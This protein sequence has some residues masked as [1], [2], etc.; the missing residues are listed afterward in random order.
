MEKCPSRKGRNEFN[1]GLNTRTAIYIPFAQAIPNVACIDPE[2]C[3]KLKTGK[4]GLCEKVCSAGAINYQQ[5]DEIIER[6]Y[7][8]IVAAT[9]FKPIDLDGF[10]EYGYNTCK[11]VVTSLEFER[12]MNAAGPTKGQLVRPSDG[13]HPHEIVFIQCV[14][15]RCS[16]DAGK[17]KPYCSKICCMYTAK[18][19]MLVRDK[20]PDVNVHVFYIDVRTP[21]KN[22]D[23]F[24]RRA[25][26]QY[27]VEYIKGMVGKVWEQDGKLM[28]QGSDLINNEQR[29]IA[30]DMVVLA[31]GVTPDTAL[32]KDAGL[33]LGIKGSIV[34][35]DRMET[36]VEDIYA[37]GDAVQVSHLV[38]GDDALI[39][40]AGPANKQGRVAAD[41]ICGL[42]S[43][44]AGAQGTS[45]IKVFD[46]TAAATGLSE[47]ACERAGIAHDAVVLSP[48]SHAGY[49]PGGKVMTM[50]VVFE[51]GT[52]RLLGAQIVGYEGVD[53]RIDVLATAIHAGLSALQLKDLDLAYAPPYS[54]AKDPVNMAGFMIENLSHGLV[55][56]FFPEDVDALP[57]DGS[58]T[59]LD[60]RTPGEYAAG[61]AE[62]FVNLPV[63]DLRE[64]L[65]EIPADKPVY[66][67]CQSAL[68][69][70]IACR[71][72]SQHGLRCSHLS[73]GWRL[74][75]A[76]MRD[77]AAAQEAL[78]CGME[79]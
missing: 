14:G 70:Y 68:R 5:E 36:G 79:K 37:V 30:A 25:V 44:F 1:M 45:V 77:R 22:F 72:L 16:D 26:E 7:G 13:E 17:G 49:Y 24:Y 4:C 60:V 67:I 27:G 21:G 57:R 41:V 53:K 6:Q 66:L 47:A 55:E 74:Y 20:Y 42:D 12:I 23:E 75:E 63:D 65:A 64:H 58:A 59:L 50:K 10:D 48:M 18:H 73:G 28:V 51:K 76:V 62:G 69:S 46:L 32:A 9:G 35:N 78:P 38:T 39:S 43:R 19:A 54:S 15:S 3:I 2:Q 61:H 40:L 34:V 29:L 33:E 8:A 11:D 71:I 52:Y 31:I 56:Q